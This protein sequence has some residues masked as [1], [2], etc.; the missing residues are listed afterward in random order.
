MAEGDKTPSF[1]PGT[2]LAG[3]F[4]IVRLVAQG[5]MERSTRPRT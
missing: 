3:R 5:G 2:L 4:R 1:S